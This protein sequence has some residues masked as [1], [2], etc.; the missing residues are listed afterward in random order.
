MRTFVTITPLHCSAFLFLIDLLSVATSSIR[1]L[2]SSL[3]WTISSSGSLSS[4]VYV[5]V[6]P[7]ISIA[8]RVIPVFLPQGNLNL[9]APSNGSRASVGNHVCQSSAC[10]RTHMFH[11]RHEPAGIDAFSRLSTMLVS[12]FPTGIKDLSSINVDRL[13]GA[14]E[15]G[16]RTPMLFSNWAFPL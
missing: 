10:G 8:T 2:A 3:I 15:Y 6:L 14:V 4:E 12:A 16:F 11:C 13:Y 1:K 9:S 5:P 7:G